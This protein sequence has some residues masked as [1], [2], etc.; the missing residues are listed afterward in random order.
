[1]INHSIDYGR[2]RLRRV[3]DK[4]GGG[5]GTGYI[6][7]KKKKIVIYTD[8][9]LSN[10]RDKKVFPEKEYDLISDEDDSATKVKL[11]KKKSIIAHIRELDVD[12]IKYI[13]KNYKTAFEPKTSIIVLS[14][15]DK[16]GL[17]KLLDGKDIRI[18]ENGKYYN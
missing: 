1:M 14:E 11:I 3:E 17:V 9:N 15:E 5:T 7:E 18:K 16:E 8:A 2:V 10:L 12:Q 6:E 4:M 13:M